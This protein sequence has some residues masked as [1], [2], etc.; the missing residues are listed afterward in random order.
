MVSTTPHES[1][2]TIYH[3][4][5]VLYNLHKFMEF[6]WAPLYSCTHWLRPRN[7]HPPTAFG[8]YWSA[9]TDDISL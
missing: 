9:K 4:F 7:S 1:P 3:S 2:I 8:R 6:I 5:T